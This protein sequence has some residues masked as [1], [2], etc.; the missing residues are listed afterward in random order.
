MAVLK[1]TRFKRHHCWILGLKGGVIMPKETEF[2]LGIK[3]PATTQ[4]QNNVATGTMQKPKQIEE[5]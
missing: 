1:N 2:D 5:N 3:K 4:A